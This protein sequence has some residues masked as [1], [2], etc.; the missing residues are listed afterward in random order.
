MGKISCQF[1]PTG[2][3]TDPV[4]FTKNPITQKTIKA[5]LKSGNIKHNKILLAKKYL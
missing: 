3:R 4:S 1:L 5:G 2:C